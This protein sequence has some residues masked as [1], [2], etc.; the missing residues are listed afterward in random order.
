LDVLEGT[1]NLA[2][3][4]MNSTLPRTM[5]IFF[6]LPD[7]PFASGGDVDRPRQRGL[8]RATLV[9]DDFDTIGG[10]V[11]PQMSHGLS[12]TSTTRWKAWNSC[13]LHAKVVRCASVQVASVVNKP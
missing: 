13:V 7:V 9:D 6:A 2:R 5:A 1:D 8:W 12:A 3:L 4:K 10:L 11:A